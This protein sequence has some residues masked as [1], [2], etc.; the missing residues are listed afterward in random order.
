MEGHDAGGFDPLS[1]HFQLKWK[2]YYLNTFPDSVHSCGAV[3][4]RW[5]K[6]ASVPERFSEFG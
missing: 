4:S 1:P 5:R 2:H 3:Q 6:L